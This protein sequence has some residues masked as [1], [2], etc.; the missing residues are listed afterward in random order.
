M[1]STKAPT[2][3]SQPAD[4]LHV[5]LRPKRLEDVIGQGPVIK[6]LA[7]VLKSDRRP[8]AYLFTGPSGTG[9]TTLG[10]IVAAAVGTLPM[11][12]L[13][14]DAA[15]HSGVDSMREVTGMARYAGFGA[16]TTR[17]IIVD[18][19]HALSKATWESLLLSI[20]HPP[21]HVYWILCTTEDH[22]VP[23]TIRTRCHAYELKAVNADDIA[24]YLIR[25]A[26]ENNIKTTEDICI[27]AARKAEG[28]VRQAIQY[29]SQI[30]GITDKQEAMSLMAS[31]IEDPQII[32]LARRLVD[33]KLTWKDVTKT[34]KGNPDVSPETVR[35]T[36]LNYLAAVALNA[37]G[38]R[39]ARLLGA[40]QHFAEPYRGNEKLAP[41]LLSFGYCLLSG[42]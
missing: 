14:I 3:G 40:M 22:K 34:L 29:L 8:H 18:E 38:D 11:N 37:D 39:A 17:T 20:E 9:K 1:L 5:R 23:K 26:D 6:S 4:P 12:I 19:A 10:R 13:E 25:I 35:L 33:D 41:V 30:D 27:A 24:D 36:V 16:S 2:T 42:D 7:N 31:V 32:D 21:K 28:S 15:T